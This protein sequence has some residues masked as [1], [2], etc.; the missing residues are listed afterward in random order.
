MKIFTVD[1]RDSTIYEIEAEN[2]EEA[3]EVA[4]EYWSQR[5]PDAY[6][7]GEDEKE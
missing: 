4:L 6:V 2:Q 1:V 5:E 7:I 3:I